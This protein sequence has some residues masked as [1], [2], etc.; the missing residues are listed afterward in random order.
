MLMVFQRCGEWK[1]GGERESLASATS[2]GG[3]ER[4]RGLGVGGGGGSG[5]EKGK[6]IRW[7]R[8]GVGE[9][10]RR[11][12][13]IL[14]VYTYNSES[15]NKREGLHMFTSEAGS[16]GVIEVQVVEPKWVN[17]EP[18]ELIGSMHTSNDYMGKVTKQVSMELE[19][20]EQV[21]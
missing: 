14:R 18:R 1:D 4:R 10:M 16:D 11:N 8:G 12:G 19:M 5:R 6:G 15:W 17:D 9:G 20:Q 7:G 2:T 13:T 3:G 21:K